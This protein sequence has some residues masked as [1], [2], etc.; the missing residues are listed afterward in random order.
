M[1]PPALELGLAREYRKLQPG[2]KP[3]SIRQ[4]AFGV[5]KSQCFDLSGAGVD[6]STLPQTVDSSLR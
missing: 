1:P 2:V 4:P 3:L 5:W 6:P